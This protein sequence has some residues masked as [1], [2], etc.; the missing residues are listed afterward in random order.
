[1]GSRQRGKVSGSGFHC[2][3]ILR[4]GFT[5][6]LVTPDC[7]VKW[8][9]NLTSRHEGAKGCDKWVTHRSPTEE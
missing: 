1:M 7:S 8:E 2:G 5:V 6:E 4:W 9:V 3:Y